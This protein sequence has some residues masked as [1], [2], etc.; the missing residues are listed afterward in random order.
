MCL[1]A[2]HNFI[3]VFDAPPWTMCTNIEWQTCVAQ[4]KLPN[5][6]GNGATFARAPKSLTMEELWDPPDPCL[7][8]NC[9]WGFATS[10]V[11]FWE[12]CFFNH[13]CRNKADLFRVEVGELFECDF[14]LSAF[15]TLQHILK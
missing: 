1:A 9:Q 15:Q 4:G 2:R 8:G 3:R 7:S 14:D 5:Q 10:D 12:V 11:F 13:V 6:G